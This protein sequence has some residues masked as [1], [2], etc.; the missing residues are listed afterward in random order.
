M[1]RQAGFCNITRVSSFRVDFR[2]MRS[3]KVFQDSSEIV[4]AGHRISLNVVAKVCPE[5]KPHVPYTG[6]SID[7]TRATPFTTT[8]V[9]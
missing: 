7:A 3:G 5:S 8:L 4:F 9:V 6:F 2:E 1:L